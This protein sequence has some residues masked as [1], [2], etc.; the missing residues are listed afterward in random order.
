[1]SMFEVGDKVICIRGVEGTPN[2]SK[3]PLK[4]GGRYTVSE[5][6]GINVVIKEIGLG[7]NEDRFIK[8]E[9]Q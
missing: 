8:D 4:T 6:Y 2:I 7:Y 9:T 1:M 3:E 5:A